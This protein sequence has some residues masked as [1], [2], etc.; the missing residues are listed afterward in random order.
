M[1]NGQQ[2]NWIW[3][4]HFLYL[5]DL[6]LSSEKHV[7]FI[8]D[9]FNTVSITFMHIILAACTD[10]ECIFKELLVLPPTAKAK[11]IVYKINENHS[12]FA[13]IKISIPSLNCEKQPWIS[14]KSLED[15]DKV[16][17]WWDAYNSIKHNKNT[18]PYRGA[19]LNYSFEALSGL[20]GVNLAYYGKKIGKDFSTEIKLPKFFSF[21]GLGAD[22]MLL[23][24]SF[25]VNVP[26]FL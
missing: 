10:I 12:D 18:K 14:L 25:N 19:N 4:E 6:L 17:L 2:I 15:K 7:A 21:P 16:P 3:W 22:H 5:E 13:D 1:N 11:D 9:N 8:E 20:L 26:G 24:S 23:E